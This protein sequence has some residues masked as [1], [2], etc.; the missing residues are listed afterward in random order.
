MSKNNLLAL[1]MP[2]EV[3]QKLVVFFGLSPV[4]VLTTDLLMGI[5]S[6]FRQLLSGYFVDVFLCNGFSCYC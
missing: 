2:C 5:L 3:V 1:S 4:V 6:P